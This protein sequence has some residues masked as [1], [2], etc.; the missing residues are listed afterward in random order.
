MLVCGDDLV[1]NSDPASEAKP[2]RPRANGNDVD[3]RRTTRED[4]LGRERAK[5]QPEQETNQRERS[6]ANNRD[7]GC[8]RKNPHVVTLAERGALL[9][10]RTNTIDTINVPLGLAQVG[11]GERRE[12]WWSWPPNWRPY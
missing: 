11:T 4:S 2:I 10:V 8:S 3:R 9:G 1:R 12:E 6:G 5:S 7:K